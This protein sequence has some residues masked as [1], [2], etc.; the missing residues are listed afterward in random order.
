MQKVILKK[1]DLLEVYY[2][3]L[4]GKV[5]KRN[6]IAK[7]FKLRSTSVSDIVTAL[8]KAGLLMEG[9]PTTNQRGRPAAILMGNSARFCTIFIQVN[10]RVIVA[11]ATDLSGRLIA[12]ATCEPPH[13][14]DNDVMA[15][16]LLGLAKRIQPNIPT[17]S[18]ICG[19]VCSLPGVLDCPRHQW[20]FI[21]R[22]PN[23]QALDLNETFSSLNLKTFYIRN[24]DAELNSRNS[25]LGE[26][27]SKENTLLLHWGYGIGAAYSMNGVIANREQGQFCEVGHWRMDNGA[28]VPCSCGSVDC[29]ETV[30][31][32][33][34]IGPKLRARWPDLPADEAGLTQVIRNFPL[35]EMDVM[36]D[37]LRDIIRV[38]GNLC[39][40]L[41]PARIIVTGPFAHNSMIFSQLS[42]GIE[43]APFREILDRPIITI[44]EASLKHEEVGALK[45][46]YTDA[47]EELL[48]SS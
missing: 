48:S 45:S 19:I 24:L 18:E 46:I 12:Q 33:W 27:W 20:R 2:A 23:L 21:S 40:I 34:S 41:F 31:S 3:V 9:V 30:A 1:R 15:A 16:A 29:L 8:L 47:I 38:I 14:A 42:E 10:G 37:A 5:S 32:L 13:D 35:L 6:D 43:A 25:D 4:N 7:M 28:G 36:Q 11:R 17:A 22:W 44:G 39:R 26:H